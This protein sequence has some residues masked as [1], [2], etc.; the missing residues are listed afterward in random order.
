MNIV[1]LATTKNTIEN[2]IIKNKNKQVEFP[3][4]IWNIIKSYLQPLTTGDAFTISY[5]LFLQ[6]HLNYQQYQLYRT[7]NNNQ[8]II[9]KNLSDKEMLQKA[10][11]NLAY[12]YAKNKWDS[13]CKNTY[14]NTTFIQVGY[15][16]AL[17]VPYKHY[18]INCERYPIHINITMQGI[19]TK[20]TK[21]YLNMSP[22]PK[23]KYI[24][25][26]NKNPNFTI[27][28][29]QK[30][31][32]LWICKNHIDVMYQYDFKNEIDTFKLQNV[33]H[34]NRHLRYLPDLSE[35][36]YRLI[37]DEHTELAYKEHRRI[38]IEIKYN[39]NLFCYHYNLLDV[40]GGSRSIIYLP[41]KYLYVKIPITYMQTQLRIPL[42][43]ILNYR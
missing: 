8:N 25:E 5:N 34:L 36:Y 13:K 11:V 9:K 27:T 4:E 24:K 26:Y 30:K 37:R 28:I 39:D 3:E 10:R 6:E 21:T 40:S 31:D 18:G 2:T 7:L 1:S 17:H 22:L 32:V 15:L 23:S 29:G 20:V 14:F 41:S 33:M 43:Q 42:R 38:N 12:T 19:I 16:I 35:L